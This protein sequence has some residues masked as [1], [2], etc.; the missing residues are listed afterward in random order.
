MTHAAFGSE[1][2]GGDGNP[3]PDV[4]HNIPSGSTAL[5]AVQPVGKAGTITLSK[6]ADIIVSGSLEHAGNVG[7]GLGVA[8]GV[9]VGVFVGV[10]V[11]V[12]VGVFV[13]V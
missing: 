1:A 3:V 13:G 5:V 10:L 8:V 12:A 2:A 7:V 4:C 6:F 9:F 11:G